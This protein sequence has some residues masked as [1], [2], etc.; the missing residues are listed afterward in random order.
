MN[1]GQ[2]TVAVF[3]NADE[4]TGNDIKTSAFK[5]RNKFKQ[6]VDHGNFLEWLPTIHSSSCTRIQGKDRYGVH[7]VNHKPT[8]K[9]NTALGASRIYRIQ[10]KDLLRVRPELSVCYS[11]GRC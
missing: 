7:L 5:I 4:E 11:F 2:A 6:P 3:A 10:I 8:D 1:S 9:V